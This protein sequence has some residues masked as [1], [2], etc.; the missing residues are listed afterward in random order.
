MST[1]YRLTTPNGFTEAATEEEAIARAAELGIEN[2]VI[3]PIEYT[4]PTPDP[5]AA[6][7]AGL[8]RA[9]AFGNLT[10]RRY[11]AHFLG[12]GAKAEGM[13]SAI[14]LA[15][16]DTAACLIGGFLTDAISSARAIPPERKDPKYITD[17]M[18]L[19]FINEIETYLG[20]PLSGRL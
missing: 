13:T 18:L 12:M 8:E 6:Y 1:K 19:T 9:A 17:A 20:T 4:L 3:E 7:A 15:L 16:V 14:R 11:Q 5:D 10:L 2:P